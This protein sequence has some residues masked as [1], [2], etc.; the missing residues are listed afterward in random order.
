MLHVRSTYCI[1][2]IIRGENTSE[3]IYPLVLP[4]S[5]DRWEPL[6]DPRQASSPFLRFPCRHRRTR[7]DTR[8]RAWRGCPDDG[9]MEGIKAQ[10]VRP[11]RGGHN[12][13]VD[14]AALC[15]SFRLTCMP[16]LVGSIMDK[17][18]GMQNC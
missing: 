14:E 7:L 16:V 1:Q 4:T 15:A 9:T 18:V 2:M 10:V 5:S 3:Q 17:A 11:Y 6:I 12:L 8:A 13:H